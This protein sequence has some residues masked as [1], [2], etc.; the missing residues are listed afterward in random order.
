LA[1]H[2][3]LG[4]TGEPQKPIVN[5]PVSNGVVL[6]GENANQIGGGGGGRGQGA[7]GGGQQN[8][9][10]QNNGGG[11]GGGGSLDTQLQPGQGL[12]P[13]GIDRIL[14]DPATNSLIAYGTPD[15]INELIGIVESLD[16]APRQVLVTLQFVTTSESLEKSLGIDW[17]YTRGSVF[18]GN[19]PGSFARSSDPVFINY[20]TGNVQT[21]LRTLLSEGNGRVVSAPSVRT[22][23]NVPAT[24]T[25]S[26][27][28]WIFS[29]VSQ[30][31]PG[32]IQT[33][34]QPIPVSSVTQISVKPRINGDDTIT[35]FLAP[36]V[37]EF[38]E[39]RRS[40]DG[41]EF[42]DI[43]TQAISLVTRVKN[44]ETIALAG[45][46]RKQ[47]RFNQSRI[48]LLSDLPI[49]GRLFRGTTTSINHQD[50][51]IFVTARILDEDDAG[52]GGP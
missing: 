5:T 19:R 25:N 20:A 45:L 17:L 23:E 47:D 31:G 46:T 3:V 18:A 48:P 24:A 44:G 7:G 34:F 9:G 2:Q 28:T 42:P 36:Q 38:G 6:P 12:V 49:I 16:V 29:V 15:A 14:Y 10:G 22:L 21:R 30:N 37:S 32:G 40:P 41:S 43:L 1:N 27:Q 26:V 35:M 4:Y 11:A 50:L 33:V 52:L 13:Q 8:G 39:I 51:V